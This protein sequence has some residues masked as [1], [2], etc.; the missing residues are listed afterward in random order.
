MS[1]AQS[2][3]LP[4][5]AW[6]S[7]APR[8]FLCRRSRRAPHTYFR[9]QISDFRFQRAP[10]AA[11]W[12]PRGLLGMVL[13]FEPQAPIWGAHSGIIRC[14]GVEEPAIFSLQSYR[15]AQNLATLV[16]D[17]LGAR[18][19]LEL[20]LWST[21]VLYPFNRQAR[22]S[23]GGDGAR[24]TRGGQDAVST[25]PS[26]PYGRCFCHGQGSAPPPSLPGVASRC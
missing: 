21:T 3:A 23:W 12:V 7:V 16:A 5:Q 15:C 4:R 17:D 9:F 2:R 18:H 24:A 10:L 1:C 6:R 13:S 19:R 14:S 8:A 22:L 26:A 11:G 20:G 25:R